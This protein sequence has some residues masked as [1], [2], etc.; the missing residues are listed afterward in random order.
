MKSNKL[1]LFKIENKSKKWKT[2]N[3]KFCNYVVI[4]F[5]IASIFLTGKF[6]PSARGARGRDTSG[7]GIPSSRYDAMFRWANLRTVT[8]RTH[9]IRPPI[10]R[11]NK[12]DA[13]LCVTSCVPCIRNG[14]WRRHGRRLLSSLTLLADLEECERHIHAQNVLLRHQCCFHLYEFPFI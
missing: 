6:L 5:C 12:W 4:L 3:Y 8:R 7:V 9:V 11:G 10:T 2:K 14:E 13:N 1:F